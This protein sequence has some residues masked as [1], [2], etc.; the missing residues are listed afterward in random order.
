MNIKGALNKSETPESLR[1]KAQKI[2]DKANK[3]RYNEKKY[4]ELMKKVWDLNTQAANLED[5]NEH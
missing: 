5:K 1:L 2:K 4:I 3:I